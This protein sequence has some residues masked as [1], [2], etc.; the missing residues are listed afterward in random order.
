MGLVVGV[1][2]GNFLHITLTALPLLTTIS[3]E[4]SV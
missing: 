1:S 3:F 2:S 4:M